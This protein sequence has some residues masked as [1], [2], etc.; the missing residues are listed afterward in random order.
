MI[1][2]TIQSHDHIRYVERELLLVDLCCGGQVEERFGHGESQSIV[3][4]HVHG[5]TIH[6]VMFSTFYFQ[7]FPHSLNTAHTT[8]VHFTVELL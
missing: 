5:W 1:F 4:E 7:K 2:H 3:F 8:L 6:S